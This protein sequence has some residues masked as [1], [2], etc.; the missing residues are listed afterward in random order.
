MRKAPNTAVGALLAWSLAGAAS[1]APAPP[2]AALAAATEDVL[3]RVCTP[4]LR[5][6]A[7]SAVLQAGGFRKGATGFVKRVD[8]DTRIEAPLDEFDP[9]IECA[10]VVISTKAPP[11]DVLR[12][13]ADWAARADPAMAQVQPRTRGE[14]AGQTYFTTVFRSRDRARDW[15]LAV[16]DYG[17]GAG[18]RPIARVLLSAK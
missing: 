17:Q 7:A 5:G 6:E 1:A 18:E 3:Q 2:P 9:K 4:L 11:E 14:E 13:A 8:A 15:V 12:G 16:E 10:F